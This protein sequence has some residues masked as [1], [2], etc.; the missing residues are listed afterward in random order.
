MN[1]LNLEIL[2]QAFLKGFAKI[3]CDVKLYGTVR[4]VIIYWAET[5]DVYQLLLFYEFITFL[6]FS[7]LQMFERLLPRETSQCLFQVIHI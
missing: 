2:S 4:N 1:I 5:F 7:L 3:A 6:L